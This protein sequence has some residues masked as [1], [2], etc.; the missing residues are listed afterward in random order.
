MAWVYARVLVVLTVVF[1]LI[2]TVLFATLP[3]V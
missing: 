2:L 3:P 1:V